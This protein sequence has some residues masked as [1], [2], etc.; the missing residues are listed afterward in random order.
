MFDLSR[1]TG[2]EFCLNKRLA[3]RDEDGSTQELNEL[4]KRKAN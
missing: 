2:D 1:E 4:Q 3:D